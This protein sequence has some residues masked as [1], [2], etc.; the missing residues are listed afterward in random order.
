MLVGF[1]SSLGTHFLELK[2]DL[3]ANGREV[4]CRDIGCS[5]DMF[6][7]RSARPM[8]HDAGPASMHPEP[9]IRENAFVNRLVLGA[10]GHWETPL[11]C[12]TRDPRIRKP[13]LIH[14]ASEN[15]PQSDI[16]RSIDTDGSSRRAPEKAI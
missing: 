14:G 3:L 10:I 15:V 7:T 12:K 8:K 1:G 11:A 2:D 6:D 9:I 4:Q 13:A 5:M 16:E